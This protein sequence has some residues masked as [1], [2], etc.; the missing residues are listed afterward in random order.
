MIGS[1]NRGNPHPSGGDYAEHSDRR[2]R[3]ICCDDYEDHRTY[4]PAISLR[5][6]GGRG[7]FDTI[8]EAAPFLQPGDPGSAAAGLCDFLLDKLHYDGDTGA[9]L[10]L[11]PP[12]QPGSDGKIDW[13]GFGGDGD[14]ILINVRSRSARCCFGVVAGQEIRDLPLGKGKTEEA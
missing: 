13:N 4:S 12:P 11:D 7:A 1:Q 2:V 9:T 10:C 3:F 5:V 6:G 14:I 8:R